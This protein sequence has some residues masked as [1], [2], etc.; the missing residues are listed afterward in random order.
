MVGNQATFL[1]CPRSASHADSPHAQHVSQKLLRN[2]ELIG[3]RPVLAHK[4]P[5][6]QTRLN[7]MKSK[8]R[9]RD[10]K[11]RHQYINITQQRAL[12][13]G[14]CKQQAAKAWH[15]DPPC[16]PSPLHQGLKRR[17]DNCERNMCAQHAFP[18][19]HSHLQAR[20]APRVCNH[21]N[22]SIHRKVDMAKTVSGIAKYVLQSQLHGA[23]Q[24]F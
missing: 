15:I 10:C 14:T 1:Q 12:Q 11:L 17:P 13:Y 5:S 6:G 24:L 3:M 8:T 9:C 7:L 4:Q 21:G 22:K 2:P 16:K 23:T 20:M 18:P 19:Y